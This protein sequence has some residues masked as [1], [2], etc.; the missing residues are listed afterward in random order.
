MRTFIK[1][2]NLSSTSL[3]LLPEDE[4]AVVDPVESVTA[5]VVSEDAVVDP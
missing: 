2:T 5:V 4:L 3:L 1:S